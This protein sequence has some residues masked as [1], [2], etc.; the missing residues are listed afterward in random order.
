MSSDLQPLGRREKRHPD[1]VTTDRIADRTCVEEKRVDSAAFGRNA[2]GQPDRTGPDDDG[3]F[4]AHAVVL[5]GSRN[6]EKTRIVTVCR[7]GRKDRED[8]S[9]T[10]KSLLGCETC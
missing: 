3:L 2:A 7:G 6:A 5:E 9:T 10:P 8:D 4:L 1:G